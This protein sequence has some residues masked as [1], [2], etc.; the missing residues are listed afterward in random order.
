MIEHA[1]SRSIEGAVAL[2]TGA[3]SGI[4]QACAELFAAHGAVVIATDVTLDRAVAVAGRIADRDHKV[5]ARKLDV[6]NRDDICV[7]V[8]E[9]GESLGRLDIIV[10]NAGT[11]GFGRFGDEGFDEAWARTLDINLTAHQRIVRQ[12]LPFLRAAPDPRVVNIAS[13]EGFAATAGLA[14]YSTSKAAVMG[15]T[16]AMAAEFGVDGII[17]NAVCPG[18]VH[19]DMVDFIAE[20][21]KVRFAKRRTALGRYAHPIEIADMA[22][23]LS[24]PSASFITGASVVVDGGFLARLS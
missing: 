2:V 14:S 20:E 4:G 8:Q 12:A 15:M 24:L 6:S 13:V 18:P 10:N 5:H 19:T 17:V 16:R 21:D 3:G 7:V 9:V 11:P 23:S 1:R 22:L